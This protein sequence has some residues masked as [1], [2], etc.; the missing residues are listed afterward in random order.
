[1]AKKSNGA[2]RRAKGRTAT[3][4]APRDP[5]DA[6]LELA[7]QQGWRHTSLAEIAAAAQVPI[8]EL[9]QQ[10]PSKLAILAGFVRRIDLALL[11]AAAGER[12]DEAPRDRLFDVI[13]RRLDLLQPHRQALAAILRDPAAVCGLAHPG[14]R[15]LRWMLAA[16]GIESEGPFGRLRAA[17]LAVIYADTLRVWLGD[18][19]KD[20]ARTMAALDRRLRQ[21]ES[22]IRLLPGRRRAAAKAEE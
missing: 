3:D 12:G 11:N 8:G 7:A 20:L 4:G 9:Y 13:M 18:E 17:G 21:A 19:S 1:M 16:A 5:I 22:L 6:A 10:Y 15:S 14:R 2:G